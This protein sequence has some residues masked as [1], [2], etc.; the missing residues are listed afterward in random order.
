M[1]QFMNN[2]KTL[3]DNQLVTNLNNFF[4]RTTNMISKSDQDTIG[5]FLCIESAFT[6][7][8]LS[9]ILTKK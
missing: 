3:L 8:Q 6:T 5:L 1:N 2:N 4:N 9:S 7:D